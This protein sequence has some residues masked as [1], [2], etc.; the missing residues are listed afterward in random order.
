[1]G[2]TF[3]I[4]FPRVHRASETSPADTDN[5]IADAERGSE[6][7]LL[8]EDESAVRYAALEFFK[9]C[10]YVVIEAKDGLS[11]VDAVNKHTGVIDLV[12]TDVVMPG[13]GGGQ[14]AEILVGKYIRVLFMSG[15]AE[16]IVHSH[17]IMDLEVRCDFLQK[18]F[19]LRTLGRKVRQL[20]SKTAVPLAPPRTK[21][22][23]VDGPFLGPV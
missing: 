8:V 17:K 22:L 20:L 15:Y 10:G 2:T 16:T 11:A 19:N 7:L 3:K 23:M 18:S 14:L 4:Y 9:K 13:M 6:T 21:F 12:V 1:M 5:R